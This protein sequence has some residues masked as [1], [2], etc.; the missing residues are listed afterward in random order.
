[1]SSSLIWCL[2]IMA[3][4]QTKQNFINNFFF[5]NQKTIY[6][7]WFY[8]LDI[9]V[10]FFSNCSFKNLEKKIYRRIILFKMISMYSWSITKWP[11]HPVSSCFSSG[12]WWYWC[13]Y[14][15]QSEGF[16]LTF[17]IYQ[18]YIK[19]VDYW[20]IMFNTDAD[21][22]KIV[23]IK[24]TVSHMNEQYFHLILQE[25]FESKDFLIYLGIV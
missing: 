25:Y 4:C 19:N 14:L 3:L 5:L 11:V 15:E 6:R 8:I 24:N 7:I 23:R 17:H 1:M 12:P 22:P 2:I 16:K 21:Y 9:C 10:L 18:H 13:F 20:K